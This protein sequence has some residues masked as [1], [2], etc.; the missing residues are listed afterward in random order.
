MQAQ[1][2][3]SQLVSLANQNHVL[4]KKFS[5]RL[6]FIVHFSHFNRERRRKLCAHNVSFLQGLSQ[7]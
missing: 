5:V 7:W 3:V 1:E 4:I 2:V 6:N